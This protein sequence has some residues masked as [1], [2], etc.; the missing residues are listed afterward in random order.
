MNQTKLLYALGIYIT[1][2]FA[3]N[4][5]GMKTMPFLFDTHISFAVFTL[6]FIFVTTDVIGQIYGKEMS[7]KFVL[8]WTIALIFFTV[9]SFFSQILPW[10]AKT[11]A[12]IGEAYESIFSIS[13]RIALASTIAFAVSEYIDVL[14]FFAVKKVWNFALSSTISNIISQALDTAIFMFIAF[15]GIFDFY[16]ILMMSIPWWIYKVMAGILYLPLSLFVLK[17]LKHKEKVW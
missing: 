15:W 3:S 14:V 2:L 16:T 1:A 13:L 5:L 4:L 11:Y 6:P 7:K 8:I 17:I 12:R 9:F 10:E